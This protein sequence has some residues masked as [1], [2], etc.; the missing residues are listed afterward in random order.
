MAVAVGR[1]DGNQVCARD[2]LLHNFERFPP[3]NHLAQEHW[4]PLRHFRCVQSLHLGEFT[5]DSHGP[6]QNPT[7]KRNASVMAGRARQTAKCGPSLVLF[8][9]RRA[10]TRFL[11]EKSRLDR[12]SPYLS[13]PSLTHYLTSN[14]KSSGEFTPLGHDSPPAHGQTNST[15]A[16]LPGPTSICKWFGFA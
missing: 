13:P 8:C 4:K 10:E 14:T 15:K 7:P 9:L 1:A 16:L 6:Q 2:P 5:F 3:R 12:V 11:G